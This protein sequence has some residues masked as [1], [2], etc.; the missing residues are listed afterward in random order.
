M[1][2]EPQPT[3][4]NLRL[5]LLRVVTTTISGEKFIDNQG[6]LMK[7]VHRKNQARV[8]GKEKDAWYSSMVDQLLFGA[9]EDIT[10]HLD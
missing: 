9:D 10:K 1:L 5:T 4:I 8:R 3:A 2:D 6:S 7:Q